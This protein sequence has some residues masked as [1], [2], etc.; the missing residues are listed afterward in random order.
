MGMRKEEE[1]EEEEGRR[2]RGEELT[3]MGML[4]ESKWLIHQ[5]L[6][7]LLMSACLSLEWDGKGKGRRGRE[8]EELTIMG[9]DAFGSGPRNWTQRDH[10]NAGAKGRKVPAGAWRKKWKI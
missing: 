5:P 4:L 1:E 6:S 9:A 7:F 10:P 2:G 8:G 3:I